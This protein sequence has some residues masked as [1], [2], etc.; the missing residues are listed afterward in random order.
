MN[1]NAVGRCKTH[2]RI[3]IIWH[4][5]ASLHLLPTYHPPPTT[6]HLPPIGLGTSQCV[7]DASAEEECHGESWG[8][9]KLS[10]FWWSERLPWRFGKWEHISIW[11]TMILPRFWKY[12]LRKY[13]KVPQ[14]PN[15]GTGNFGKCTYIF[16]TCFIEGWPYSTN[17][18]YKRDLWHGINM[19]A[20]S[21]KKEANKNKHQKFGQANRQPTIT[22]F[23]VV[24]LSNFRSFVGFST[25][26]S[27]PFADFLFWN[28]REKLRSRPQNLGSRFV[29]HGKNWS[30]MHG[31]PTG[32]NRLNFW[33]LHTVVSSKID[34][35]TLHFYVP[36]AEW[37]QWG[38]LGW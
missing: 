14:L 24:E 22:F 6:H 27:K 29:I 28:L 7:S 2:L 25:L 20:L 16:Y 37:V 31:M 23:R 1:I 13:I 34:V 3:P 8:V 18:T 30:S 17:S 33:G 19:T 12:L 10:C 21:V 4:S 9:G 38:V 32:S 35:Q 5:Q 26:P 11:G 36:S 15:L